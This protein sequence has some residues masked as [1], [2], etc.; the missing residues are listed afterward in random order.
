MYCASSVCSAK[1]HY[2]ALSK[3]LAKALAV[4]PRC[5]ELWVLAAKTEH[6]GNRNVD[7][8]RYSGHCDTPCCSCVQLQ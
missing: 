6:E 7:A 8:A 3:A 2:F 4:N 5:A 1:K